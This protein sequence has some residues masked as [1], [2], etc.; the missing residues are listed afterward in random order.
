MFALGCLTA[1]HSDGTTLDNNDEKE[2][3]LSPNESEEKINKPKGIWIDAHANL[4]RF[5]TKD[6][7]TSYLEKIKD[8]GFNEIYLDVKPGI[9]YALYDSDILAPLTKWGDEI[10]NR[11]FDYLG[12]WLEEA[13]RLDIDVI[14]TISAMGYGYTKGKEGPIY[15]D[16]RWD[17]KTQVMLPE[18]NDPTQLV[19]IRDQEDVDAAMLNPCLPEV[20]EFVISIVEEIVTKYPKLKGISLDYCRWYGGNYGFSDATI[21]AFETY[22][23]KSVTNK[24]DIITASGG[25]GTLYKDWIEFRS[26]C[27]TNLITN[28]RSKVKTINPDME[29]QL[30]ASADWGSRYSVGQNWASKKYIPDPGIRY[31]EKYNE[32]GFANQ[33]DVFVLGAEAVWIKDNPNS[34]WSV[35]NF[36]NTYDD[37]IKGDCKVYGS[38]Q[39]YQYNSTGL[40]DAIY[41]C[42]KRTDGLMIFEISHVINNNSW[43]DIKEA[44]KRIEK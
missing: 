18:N 8:T 3:P 16:S 36:V 20:Q 15:E 7:I 35:E 27:I 41:L 33:L 13:E 22:S 6:A 17:G 42:M 43:A 38:I 25:I 29:I 28:I 21:R 2:I 34:V 31:T 39:S 1:C 12:F 23:G 26:M 37:Y 40:S 32:T 19:D 44:I 24:N 14:A 10:V 9:G 30:W 4:S 5:A 11:D